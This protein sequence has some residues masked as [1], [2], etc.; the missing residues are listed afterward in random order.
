[1]TLRITYHPETRTYTHAKR[2][3]S[4]SYPIERLPEWIAF[5]KKQRLD[6]PKSGTAYDVDIAALEAL[7]RELSIPF[8]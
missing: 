6:F 4:N 7:A 8:D 3:W 2:S 1:M 5:Y